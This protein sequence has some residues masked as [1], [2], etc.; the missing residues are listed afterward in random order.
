MSLDRTIW[1]PPILE[2]LCDCP[3]RT[4]ASTGLSLE[5]GTYFYSLFLRR[6]YLYSLART[7]FANCGPVRIMEEHTG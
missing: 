2:A 5:P 1:G 6:A 7:G 3:P 4:W